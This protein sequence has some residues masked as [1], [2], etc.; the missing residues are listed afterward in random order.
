ME[1]HSVESEYDEQYASNVLPEEA[2]MNIQ[3]GPLIIDQSHNA[4]KRSDTPKQF[5]TTNQ[6]ELNH[7]RITQT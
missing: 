5:L 1:N 7:F 3:D 4:P 2:E 6:V